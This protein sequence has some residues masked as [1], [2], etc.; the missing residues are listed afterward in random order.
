MFSYGKGDLYNLPLIEIL[1]VK[2]TYE[3]FCR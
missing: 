2:F 1:Y 3:I